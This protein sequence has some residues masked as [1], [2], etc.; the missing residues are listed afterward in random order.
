MIDCY[1]ATGVIGGHRLTG[2]IGGYK[3]ID[4]ERIIGVFSGFR[5]I[6]RIGEQGTEVER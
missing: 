1:R 2:V 3:E 6:V 5:K 4:R